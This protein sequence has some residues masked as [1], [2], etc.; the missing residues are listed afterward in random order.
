MMIISSNQ[1]RRRLVLLLT[2]VGGNRCALYRDLYNTLF[3]WP[4]LIP[5]PTSFRE[6]W[7]PTE[8]VRGLKAH[9]PSPAKGISGCKEGIRSPALAAPLDRN[10]GSPP[11]STTAAP[12]SHREIK[13]L[14]RGAQPEL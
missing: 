10:R 1:P 7:I 14:G 11:R 2:Q 4:D 6:A 3:P 9:G 5:P 12:D 13:H 8:L